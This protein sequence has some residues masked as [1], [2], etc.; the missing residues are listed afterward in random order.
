MWSGM[1]DSAGSVRCGFGAPHK[2]AGRARQTSCLSAFCHLQL[3]DGCLQ[4]SLLWRP[5]CSSQSSHPTGTA[6][7]TQRWDLHAACTVRVVFE[8][9]PTSTCV[10]NEGGATI[11]PRRVRL[12]VSMPHAPHMQVRAMHNAHCTADCGPQVPQMVPLVHVKHPAVTTYLVG[13]ADLM[14]PGCGRLASASLLI[15]LRSCCW[16]PSSGRW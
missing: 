7:S 14:L 3:Q 11:R 5:E 12:R 16:P 10:R 4:P 2:P 6:R 13:G 15:L 9:E 8:V 1:T